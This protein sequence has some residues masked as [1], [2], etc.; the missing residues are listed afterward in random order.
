MGT[1]EYAH[2]DAV[3]V[4]CRI[5]AT[6]KNTI[7]DSANVR[8]AK[9]FAYDATGKEYPFDV[10]ATLY[11]QESMSAGVWYE[12]IE[13]NDSASGDFVFD[14]PVGITPTKV[15]FVGAEDSKGVEVS[16]Q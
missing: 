10:P 8:A 5:S 9:M 7:E 12:S 1:N 6:I 11:A 13:P 16:L 4:F 3:G 15:L 14:L 2:D